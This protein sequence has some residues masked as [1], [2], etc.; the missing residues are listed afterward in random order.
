MEAVQEQFL[1]QL[2]RSHQGTELGQKFGLSQIRSVDQFRDRI[3]VLP[4]SSYEPYTDRIAKG[5]RNILNPDPVV[6]INLTSGSTGKKKQVPVTRRFQQTLRKADLAAMGFLS[7]ALQQRGTSFGKSS[8]TNSVVL[9]GRTEGGIEYGPVSVGSIRQGKRLFNQLMAQPFPALLIADILSRHYVCLRFALGNRQTRGMVANFPMLLLRT[10]QYLEDYA[11]PLIEDLAQGTIAPWL[12]LEPELRS[13]LN[14]YCTPQPQRAAELR[15]ILNACG[16]LTP[17]MA[18]PELAYTMTAR[19]GTSD[20]YFERFPEYFGDL[21]SFGGVYG[22]AE[23]TFGVYPEVNQDSSILAIESGFYEF[24]P[25]TQ[26]SNRPSEYPTTLMPSEV[27]M[28][29]RYRILLT[30]YSGFYRYDIGDV[31]EVVGFYEQTPLIV[32]R[33]RLGGL[34]SSTTEKTTEYHATQVMQA[35][36]QEFNGCLEDFC[37][38][39]SEQDFPAR[40]LVNI[41]ISAGQPQPNLQQLISRFEYWMREF[42]NPYGTVRSSQVPAPRLR[43]LAPGSFAQVRQR[44]VD[45]GMFD[46]QLKFPHISEDRRFLAGLPILEEVE[47]ATSVSVS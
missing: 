35:L 5:E 38:T 29:E 10:C 43:L 46:S 47:L 11:E 23:A 45:R 14:R 27:K 16:K 4:Y 20:F 44:Q 32:F 21:P 24:M 3:P 8:L 2:L 6:Y 42:N 39:L 30:S 9:Q 7:E 25:L 37:I 13:Q 1:L 41:E 22:S 31:V 34:L 18:W 17:Q 15:A 26:P 28:G 33:H 12:K 40:Y 19:G 36:Q